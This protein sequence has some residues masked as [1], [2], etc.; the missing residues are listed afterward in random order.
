MRDIAT[1]TK[2]EKKENGVFYTPAFLADYVAQKL[3]DYYQGDK[4]IK[5]LDPACGDGILLNAFLKIN[6][7][8]EKVDVYGVDID[9]DAILNTQIRLQNVTSKLHLKNSDGLYPSDGLKSQKSWDTFRNMNNVGSGFNLIISNPPWG[10]S[11]ERYNKEKLFVDFVSSKGQFD[12]FNLFIEVIVNNLVAG[13]LY[14]LILPD[15]IFSQ[16]QK[17]IRKFILDNSTVLSISRLGEKIFPGINRACTVIIGK[18]EIPHKHHKVDCFR[19]SPDYKR[20][21]INNEVE[22]IDIDKQFKHHVL[23]SRFAGNR[24]FEFDIDLKFDDISTFK[25]IEKNPPLK[26]LVTNTRGAEI[27]KKGIVCQCPKCKNWMPYPRAKAPSCAHCG[28]SFDLSEIQIENIILSHNGKG[29]LKLKVGED[30]FRYTSFSKSWIN[31]LKK[32]INYK[33]ISIYNGEKI[34]V[35]KTGVGITASIDYENSVTNQVVYI[36]KL[37]D[38]FESNISLEFILGVLNSRAIT[39]FLLK[40]YGENEWKSHPYLTQTQ[41]VSLPFPEVDLYNKETA[42][43]VEKITNIIAS[44]VKKSANKNLSIKNDILIEREVARLFNLNKEDYKKIF[45]ALSSAEQLIP[46]KRLLNCT[47]DEIFDN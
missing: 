33:N 29:N 44:E 19:L 43:T 24:N 9:K 34:L 15:S 14:G 7:E 31:T 35:R 42:N 40:K 22:L 20:M 39:Y 38:S 8:N 13:G 12:I 32:G 11:L 3:N 26:R 23:Q 6:S 4:N 45:H 16:E 30:L 10:A 36:L 1:Y 41:L 2:E 17:L 47:V 27:S 28:T 37:N 5:L 25:K 46:I 21:I 18:K